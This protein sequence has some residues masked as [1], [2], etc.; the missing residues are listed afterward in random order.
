MSNQL[1]ERTQ[2]QLSLN[3]SRLYNPLQLPDAQEWQHLFSICSVLVKSRMLP[4]HI[5]NVEQALAMALKSRELGIPLM[6]GFAKMYMISGKVSL[7]AELMLALALSKLPGLVVNI[8]E[9][10]NGV[11]IIELIRPE[12]GSKPYVSSFSVQD[13]EKANLL[14]KAIWKQ[15]PKNMLRA[16]AITNALRAKC[17]D[18]LNGVSHSHEELGVEVDQDGNIIANAEP[19]KN[20]R[21]EREVPAEIQKQVAHV[22]TPWPITPASQEV[23]AKMDEIRKTAKPSPDQVMRMFTIA[24]AHGINKDSIKLYIEKNYQKQSAKELTLQEVDSTIS[25]IEKGEFAG[26][27]DTLMKVETFTAKPQ[28]Q[29]EENDANEDFEKSPSALFVKKEA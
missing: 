29:D 20:E 2:S 22:P 25:L 14:G 12:K 7:E 15:Y 13:A 5:Q 28:A 11:C 3:A 9:S 18:A 27:M 16:R 10:K 26:L 6:T 4:T 17:A 23:K 8:D 21:K 1:A 24:T 19:E